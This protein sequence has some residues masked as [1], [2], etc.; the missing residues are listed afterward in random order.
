MEAFI[1]VKGRVGIKAPRLVDN[2]SQRMLFDRYEDILWEKTHNGEAL[3]AMIDNMIRMRQEPSDEPQYD[4]WM[5]DILKV[6]GP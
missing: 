4:V 6:V 2:V 5:F 3:K 1:V